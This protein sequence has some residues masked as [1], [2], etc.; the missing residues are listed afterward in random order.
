MRLAA[1]IALAKIGGRPMTVVPL[2]IDVLED[3]IDPARRWLAAD[4][5]RDLG[6]AAAHAAP[7]LARA[8]RRP[9]ERRLVRQSIRL[10]LTTLRSAA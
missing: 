2:L 9:M 6:P 4:A 7:A 10:A 5:L 8:L 3:E 1:A